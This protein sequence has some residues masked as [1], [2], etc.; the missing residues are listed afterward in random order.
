[1]S[2]T[3]APT[4][5]PAADQK[6][7]SPSE[8]IKRENRRLFQLAAVG[9]FLGVATLASYYVTDSGSRPDAAARTNTGQ[10]LRYMPF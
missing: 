9:M 3:I 8:Q 2:I 6:A 7:A 10:N 1:M 4:G 5:E